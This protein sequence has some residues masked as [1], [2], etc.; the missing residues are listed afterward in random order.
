MSTL[1][2]NSLEDQVKPNLS[3]LCDRNSNKIDDKIIA[4]AKCCNAYKVHMT[5]PDIWLV[6]NKQ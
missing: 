3:W 1:K 4:K 5:G 6:P 2:C